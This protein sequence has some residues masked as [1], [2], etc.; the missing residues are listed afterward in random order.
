[1]SCYNASAVAGTLEGYVNF[2]LSYFNTSDL[3]RGVTTASV[4]TNTSHPDI[5]RLEE[6]KDKK[7]LKL[8]INKIFW[9]LHRTVV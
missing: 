6:I 9:I 8:M 5:C 1:M 7:V 4:T 3:D 2:T